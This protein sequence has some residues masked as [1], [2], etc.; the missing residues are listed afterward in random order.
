MTEKEKKPIRLCDHTANAKTKSI[1]DCLNDDLECDEGAFENGTKCVVLALD[2]TTG[3]YNISWFQAGMKMSELV[4]LL[5]MAKT[6]IKKEEMG[7]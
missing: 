3:G 4:A 5:D 6:L 2:D 7:F 1:K